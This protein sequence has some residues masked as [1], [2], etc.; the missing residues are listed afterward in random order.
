MSVAA[1]RIGIVTYGLDRPLSGVTRVASE[2]GRALLDRPGWEVTFLTAYRQGPFREERGIQSF[3]LP[4]CARLPALMLLGGPLIALAARKLRLDLVH[5]PVGVAPFTLGRWAG[6]FKRLVTVHDAIAFRDPAVYPWMNRFL[7]RSYV[8]R[9]LANIDAVVT[10]SRH[11]ADD[12]SRYLHAPP[13]P[14][15]VV[16]NGVSDRFRPASEHDAAASAS[17][18]GLP[19]RYILTVGAQ[20]ARKNV[21]GLLRA[22]AAV[23]PR[24]PGVKIAVVGPHLW[25]FDAVSREIAELGLH[26]AV[27]TLGYVP[28]GELP[29]LYTGAAAFVFPSLYEGFGLPVLEAMA[30][31]TPVITSDTSS[32]PEVAGNAALLVDPRDPVALGDAIVKVLHDP[33]LA[34][35]LRQRGYARAST[36]TWDATVARLLAVYEE[37]LRR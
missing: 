31:G 7:H 12:L 23:R 35:D 29:A 27:V 33:A 1:R 30:C 19:P 14:V 17:R 36:M 5:D 4:G 18:Y 20:Q 32:L 26:D 21:S 24:L 15:H 28:D 9:N 8:P 13:P 11:A 37:T 6:R 34:A 16:P 3:A 25:Q 10:V 22:F 2:L